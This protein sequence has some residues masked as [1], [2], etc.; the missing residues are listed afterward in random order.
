MHRMLLSFVA[1]I[2]VGG[3]W[4]TCE[5]MHEEKYEICVHP[6]EGER[7]NSRDWHR[8]TTENADRVRAALLGKYGDCIHAAYYRAQVYYYDTEEIYLRYRGDE[9]KVRG[10]TW[11]DDVGIAIKGL[12]DAQ[13]DALITHE[14]GHRVLWECSKSQ[15]Q[16]EHHREL[17]EAGL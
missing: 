17:E 16:Q 2:S 14:L 13:L 7:R 4:Y 8:K 12:T 9:W 11:Y 10:Y 5:T 1:A 15:T 6:P 3:C